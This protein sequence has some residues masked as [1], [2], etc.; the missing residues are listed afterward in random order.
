MKLALAVA[1]GL[2]L[3][4]SLGAHAQN[5]PH[6]GDSAT[7]INGDWYVASDSGQLIL[8]AR[9]GY[10]SELSGTVDNQ[11]LFCRVAA[12]SGGRAPAPTV[13]LDIFHRNGV[14]LVIKPGGAIGEWRVQDND[15]QVAIDIYE[16]N[17]I[18]R[19]DL[20]D[21]RTGDIVESVKQ[22]SDPS[23]LPQWAKSRSQLQDE[24][25]PESG[26]LE[27]ERTMWIEKAIRQIE[28]IRPGM[29]RADVVRVMT[30]EGGLSSREQRTYVY[31][32][33]PYI[34]VDIRFKAI[35]PTDE[36]QESAKDEVVSVSG[37][38]LGFSVMD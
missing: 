17:E 35:G 27:R 3:C 24:S 11:T 10:C 25:V 1:M 18:V 4:A 6:S 2:A 21:A 38:Y 28:E 20:Y 7:E 9:D 34:K 26:A 22:P 33:C 31:Q 32:G 29:T 30:T 8:V 12:P 19:H 15:G 36:F 23:T 16:Q 14:K 13:E 37:P 5:A